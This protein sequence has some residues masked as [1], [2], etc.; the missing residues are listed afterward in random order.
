[1]STP[2]VIKQSHELG[3]NLALID[4]GGEGLSVQDPRLHLVWKDGQIHAATLVLRLDPGDYALVADQGDF[5]LS[6]P[7][8]E[9]LDGPPFDGETPILLKAKLHPTALPLLQPLAEEGAQAATLFHRL[10]ETT[11]EHGLL[12]TSNWLATEVS[13]SGPRGSSRYR[14]LWD[15]L[16]ISSETVSRFERGEFN[17]ALHAFMR[18]KIGVDFGLLPDQFTPDAVD[19]LTAQVASL[20]TDS[21]RDLFQLL[22]A[23][24]SPEMEEDEE[25][26]FKGAP[27]EDDPLEGDA[28]LERVAAFLN[29]DGWVWEPMPG[30]RVIRTG[31]TGDNGQFLCQ[32]IWEP[33]HEYLVCYTLIP[34]QAAPHYLTRM[35]D[36]LNRANY[37]L[38]AGNFEIHP[39]RGEIR[40]RNSLF[41]GERR[42]SYDEIE[43][44]LYTA[45]YQTDHYLPGIMQVN[46]GIP[47]ATAI[48]AVEASS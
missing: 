31:A 25:D 7:V 8:Q 15:R 18:S 41:A 24:L 47:A 32:I 20:L 30:G 28:P 29:A 42:L 14:T 13:Q 6:E 16:K 10:A 45:V 4:L 46:K 2:T 48:A 27:V 26:F 43:D 21:L 39:Q 33:E 37:G 9:E 11:P 17:E 5:N 40:F 44:L 36:Y 38:P 23:A 34:L 22:P 1:M 35:I 12:L 3:D 19:A